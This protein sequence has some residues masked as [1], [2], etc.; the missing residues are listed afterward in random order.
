MALP[1]ENRQIAYYTSCALTT[2]ITY[3]IFCNARVLNSLHFL[4]CASAGFLR[5]L[6][7]S[8]P[9]RYATTRGPYRRDHSPGGGI[10]R[11]MRSLGPTAESASSITLFLGLGESSSG[12]C[13][14]SIG[15]IIPSIT[16]T[17]PPACASSEVLMYS[18]MASSCSSVS[19]LSGLL[20]S[21]YPVH[22]GVATRCLAHLLS[23]LQHLAQAQTVQRQKNK[24][25]N[26]DWVQAIQ[27]PVHDERA[28][29]ADPHYA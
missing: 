12:P 27:I 1:I 3:G 17:G 8:R 11:G 14:T 5:T 9:P 10:L 22:I 18:I 20:C 24:M 13:R 29:A 28:V 15:S 4:H 26:Q 2:L 21:T 19:S 6:A 23:Q 7:A 25:Q 16:L